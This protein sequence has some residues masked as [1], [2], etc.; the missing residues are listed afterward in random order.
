MRRYTSSVG[1][2][3]LV[4]VLWGRPSLPPQEFDGFGLGGKQVL[5]HIGV[6]YRSEGQFKKVEKEL[7]RVIR[8]VLLGPPTKQKDFGCSDSPEYLGP[9]LFEQVISPLDLSRVNGNQVYAMSHD[10]PLQTRS[11]D[12]ELR[13]L[14]FDRLFSD[15]HGSGFEDQCGPGGGSH[16]LPNGPFSMEFKVV[17][18]NLLSSGQ[19]SAAMAINWMTGQRLTDKDIDQT[20]GFHILS[21][22]K[23]ESLPVGFDWS[24]AGNFSEQNWLRICDTLKHNLPVLLAFDGELSPLKGGHIVLLVSSQGETVRYLDPFDGRLKQTSRTALLNAPSHPDGNFVFLP[25]RATVMEPNGVPHL[26]L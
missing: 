5:Q 25:Q 21:A 15:L 12:L 8:D 7:S 17:Q 9:Q 24:D 6:D 14:E 26:G 3:L 19:A 22:L 10:L 11:S 4:Y 13:R 23:S 16:Q 1:F 18:S 20:Y 2:V